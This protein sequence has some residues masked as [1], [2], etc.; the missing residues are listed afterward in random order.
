MLQY[1]VSHPASLKLVFVFGERIRVEDIV[2]GFEQL[3][4]KLNNTIENALGI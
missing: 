1:S 2:T 4:N 3:I